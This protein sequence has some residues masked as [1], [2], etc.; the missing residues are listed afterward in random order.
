MRFLTVIVILLFADVALGADSVSHYL[1]MRRALADIEST[2]NPCARNRHSSASG[3]YQFIKGWDAWF[4]KRA[5][6]T[7]SSVTAQ[8]ACKTSAARQDRLFDIYFNEVVSPWIIDVRERYIAARKL[9]EPELLAL[10][11][12]QGE[13]GGRAYLRSGAD[14]FA[15]KAGN[16][17]IAVH[18][19][20]MKKQMGF[21]NY[22]D[23][24]HELVR[25]A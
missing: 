18:L 22:L 15:G 9:S 23:S 3:K 11:H 5:G 20:A 16:K 14:P 6:Y 17:P 24:Q 13:A 1:T 8:P 21:Y 25:G 7:W 10:V 19:R 2:N 4:K 12:R